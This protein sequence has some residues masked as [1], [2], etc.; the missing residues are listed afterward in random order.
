MLPALARE[1][2]RSAV[3]VGPGRWLPLRRRPA[4]VG[5]LTCCFADSRHPEIFGRQIHRVIEWLEAREH[6]RR[7]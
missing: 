2:V 6:A 3:V 4:R 1:L 5:V 7:P